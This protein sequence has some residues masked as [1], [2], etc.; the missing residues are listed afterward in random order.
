MGKLNVS[1]GFALGAAICLQLACLNKGKPAPENEVVENLDPERFRQ[2]IEEGAGVVLDVRTPEEVADGHLADASTVDFYDPDFKEKLRLIPVERDVYVYCA[3]GIRSAEAAVF[4]KSL[5][6]PRVCNLEGGLQAWR[7]RGYPIVRTAP[8]TDEHLRSLSKADFDN[9]LQTEKPVL[10]N[11][12][13]LWCAPC[14]KMA[15][16]VDSLERLF[17]QR[18]VVLRVDADRSRDV[19][20]EYGVKGVPVFMLFEGNSLRWKHTG[21][22]SGDSLAAQIQRFL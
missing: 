13:T 14:R 5:G 6:H 19:A 22:I 15:P 2:L 17:L 21:V 10:V 16:V 8:G 3:S 1:L 7:D 9:L 18:A 12:H 20:K 11:F 4:L